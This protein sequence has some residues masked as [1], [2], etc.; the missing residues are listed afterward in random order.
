MKIDFENLTTL[1]A[2][3]RDDV[4]ATR[5]T[6]LSGS[7]RSFFF[8][9]FLSDL[10]RP[11]LVILPEKKEA[12]R[13]FR[14]LQFFMSNKGGQLGDHELR[15]YEFSPYDMSPLTGLSPHR[16]VVTKRLQALYALISY[17]NPVIITSLQALHFRVLP[18]NALVGSLEYLEV[19]EEVERDSLLRI[20]QATGYTR[21]SLVE[22]EGDFSVRGGVI[23]VFSTLYPLPVRLEFWGDRLESMRQFDP[24]SQRSKDAL[25][26]MILLPASEIIMESLPD[27]LR[28]GFQ[29][30]RIK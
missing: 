20:L 5:V 16:E 25:N 6:G 1:K 14:E 13:L 18:K 24:L 12:E 23:D 10:D 4:R 28:H 2:W 21:A 27:L 17:K 30:M 3:V 9:Q 29:T 22:E 11:S 26:E 15:L 7:A 8:A 19:G